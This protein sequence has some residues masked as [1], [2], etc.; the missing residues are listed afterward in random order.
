MV[1]MPKK[2]HA[3][4]LTVA[5]HLLG[6]GLLL[7][8]PLLMRWQN[9]EEPVSL[10][11]YLGY[12]AVP[13]SFMAVFYLNYLLFIPRMLFQKRWGGFAGLNLVLVVVVWYAGRLWW[14]FYTG[15]FAQTL[16]HP[17]EEKR[18][19]PQLVFFARD[20]MSFA[21]TVALAVAI[22]MTSR[23][24]QSERQRHE[25]ERRRSE[26][27]LTNLKNQ[28]NPHFLFNTLNNIY[29]LVEVNPSQAQHAVHELSRLLRYVL[30]EDGPAMVPLEKELEFLRSYIDLMSLRT[31]RH[32]AR[33]ID[34]SPDDPQA[35][36]APLIFISLVE[37]AFKHGVSPTEPSFIEIDIHTE[38][39]RIVCRTVN[40][41]FPKSDADRSGS[42]IG[43]RNLERRLKLIYGNAYT[44]SRSVKDGAYRCE[45]TLPAKPRT[46]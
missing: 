26:A 10:T 29:A 9:R 31:G 21:L 27:E 2:R 8:F 3:K 34:L 45:L 17:P 15:H 23:W 46:S 13:L 24:Q 43:I 14:N 28:L 40:S 20:V 5:I 22:K 38:N 39:G 11:W 16:P 33:R 12:V 30:Y 18:D 4:L 32:V 44:L 25:A 36:T 7:V 6:W 19:I 35:V 1:I 42:G 37:N 41:N